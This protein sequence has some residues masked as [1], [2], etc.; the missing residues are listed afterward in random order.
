MNNA[1]KASAVGFVFMYGLDSMLT[2]VT[3]VAAD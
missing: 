2:S 3:C 1:A